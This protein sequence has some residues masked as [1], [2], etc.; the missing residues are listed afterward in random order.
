MLRISSHF[1]FI[2]LLL[3]KLNIFV[4]FVTSST[5]NIEVNT[6]QLLIDITLDISIIDITALL[7]YVYINL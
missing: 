3:R 4:L 5:G 2:M 7:L 1:S 6:R